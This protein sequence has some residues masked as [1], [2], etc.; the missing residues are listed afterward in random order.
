[1]EDYR[2]RQSSLFLVWFIYFATVA[3]GVWRRC[4]RGNWRLCITR[5]CTH[6]TNTGNRP[7]L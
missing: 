1:M 7:L 6:L 2:N 5:Y 4:Y 3:M